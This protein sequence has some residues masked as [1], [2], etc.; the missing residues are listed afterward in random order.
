VKTKIK[1]GLRKASEPGPGCLFEAID[2][3]ML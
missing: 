3:L 2:G 1:E